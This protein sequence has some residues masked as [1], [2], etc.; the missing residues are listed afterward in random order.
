MRG[1]R[2]RGMRVSFGWPMRG[3]RLAK[4][5][6]ADRTAWLP[7]PAAGIDLVERRGIVPTMAHDTR[8]APRRTLPH[9]T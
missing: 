1:E 3:E 8:A 7:S 5:L 2:A 6:P 9:P 4:P